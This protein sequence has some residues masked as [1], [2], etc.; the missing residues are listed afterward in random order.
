MINALSSNRPDWT[1]C[2]DMSFKPVA[3]ALT[4][5]TM[6]YPA[7]IGRNI[8]VMHAWIGLPR[9]DWQ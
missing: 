5:I 6:A 1:C 8:D 7:L 9:L 4:I 3:S 2:S